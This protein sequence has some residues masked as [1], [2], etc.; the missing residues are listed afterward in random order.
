[1]RAGE[2]ELRRKVRRR[3]HGKRMAFKSSV[4]RGQ[5][6]ASDDLAVSVIG[7]RRDGDW[8]AIKVEQ[9]GDWAVPKARVWDSVIPEA[10]AVK[11]LNG[12]RPAFLKWPSPCPV[13]QGQVICL[14]DHGVEVRIGLPVPTKG[15]SGWTTRIHI[16]DFRAEAFLRQ[17]PPAMGRPASGTVDEDAARIDGAYTGRRELALESARGE[18]DEGVPIGWKDRSVGKREIARQDVRRE[19]EI[20]RQEQAARSELGKLTRGLTLRQREQV[21]SEIQRVI[22]QAKAGELKTAA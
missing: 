8:W 3:R 19:E 22:N 1:M 4:R 16:T 5:V 17:S 9:V 21:L 13:E 20:H 15:E 12:P 2:T 7:V 10:D 6:I 18:H 11:I 14:A